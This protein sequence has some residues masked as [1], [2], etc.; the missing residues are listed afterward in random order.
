M[1]L[2]LVL[3]FN[4]QRVIPSVNPAQMLINK[5]QHSIKEAAYF[6]AGSRIVIPSITANAVNIVC[7]APVG[8]WNT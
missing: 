6:N 1:F 5:Q 4:I 8:I 2:L 7:I 3:A